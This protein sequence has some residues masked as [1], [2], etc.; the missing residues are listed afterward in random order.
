MSCVKE[1]VY[2]FLL[3]A[4][5]LK[6][7]NYLLETDLY[8]DEQSYGIMFNIITN[9]PIQITYLAVHVSKANI[10]YM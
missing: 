4:Q 9:E 3:A 2:F 7:Q 5:I 6:C 8:S 1:A 10:T